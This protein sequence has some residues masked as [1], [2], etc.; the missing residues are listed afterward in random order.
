MS[1][2][3]AFPIPGLNIV[4]SITSISNPDSTQL[5]D[6]DDSKL[7]AIQFRLCGQQQQPIKM[8]RIRFPVNNVSQAREIEQV[9]FERYYVGAKTHHLRFH[10]RHV[11][12][13]V[14]HPLSDVLEQWKVEGAK[15]KKFRLHVVE[16]G[17]NS[18][19]PL[20]G[21]TIEVDVHAQAES[22]AV[23]DGLADDLQHRNSTVSQTSRRTDITA[24]QNGE[25]SV[26]NTQENNN[27]KTLHADDK[28]VAMALTVHL[29][30]TLA[31]DKEVWRPSIV[32]VPSSLRM[33]RLPAKME[34]L[35]ERK[36]AEDK[37]LRDSLMASIQRLVFHMDINEVDNSL[38]YGRVLDLFRDPTADGL[39]MTAAVTFHTKRV[40][41]S[42]SDAEHL[43]RPL[44]EGQEY[45][46]WR[47]G[48]VPIPDEPARKHSPKAKPQS[49]RPPP[50]HTIAYQW[51][52]VGWS[53]HNS[54]LQLSKT[55]VYDFGDF[56]IGDC[57]TDSAWF[58]QNFSNSLRFL[59]PYT[60]CSAE[61]SKRAQVQELVR[62]H[63]EAG[64]DEIGSGVPFLPP[65]T[66]NEYDAQQYGLGMRQWPEDGT[67]VAVRCI[68][69]LSTNERLTFPLH[70]RFSLPQ[71][72][73]FA[74]MDELISKAVN[75]PKEEGR[76]KRSHP[77]ITSGLLFQGAL[78]GVWEW[79]WW[80][81]PHG[82]A[83]QKMFRWQEGELTEFLSEEE[84][85]DSGARL[86]VEAHI[87]P[88]AQSR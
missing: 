71:H 56:C 69:R 65:H 51:A 32:Q 6:G 31:C 22:N 2:A 75:V 81:L 25:A 12:C 52:L 24:H 84:A 80:V 35:I 62:Q 49:V 66:L 47:I 67:D 37:T 82:P 64:N 41:H 1:F 10:D 28:L 74:E 60:S 30:P 8:I 63:D 79:E 23:E 55:P 20:A 38:R 43:V 61:G 34:K 39:K 7:L 26:N 48:N 16:R 73:G 42:K 3:A 54:N 76:A 33:D 11:G 4:F 9:L 19:A 27:R 58:K 68:N 46:Y 5:I 13:H 29:P 18:S 57:G 44:V 85:E 72:L 87:V 14:L 40:K 86:Y 70:L 88:K 50:G 45:E 21:D 17:D 78:E 36:I 53:D 83:M 59:G 77:E 15:D